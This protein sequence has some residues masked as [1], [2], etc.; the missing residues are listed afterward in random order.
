MSN[1]LERL[2]EF[3][4]IR[5]SL[6]SE[7]RWPFPMF[8]IEHDSGWDELVYNL[9]KD[10]ND[11]GF[12]GDVH[13]IKEKLGGLRFYISGGS[14]AVHERISEAERESYKTCEICG[15]PGKVKD[16]RGWLKC[17]CD[18]HKGESTWE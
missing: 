12:D 11:M 17:V 7:V 3:E 16:N 14:D 1:I 13:Q 2:Q 9:C 6:K 18:E 4:F 8:G 15:K 5:K 10:L